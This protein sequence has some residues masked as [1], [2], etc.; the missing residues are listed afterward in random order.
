MRNRG[1][2]GE[3]KASA[4]QIK[5][6]RSQCSFC[7]PGT[8]LAFFKLQMKSLTMLLDCFAPKSKVEISTLLRKVSSVPR[9]V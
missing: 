8:A 9:D 7:D 2:G 3:A 6:L 4:K 1:K 5:R